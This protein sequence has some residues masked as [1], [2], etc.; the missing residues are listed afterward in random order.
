VFSQDSPISSPE[1]RRLFRRIQEALGGADKIAAVLDFERQV[2]AAS[3]N[4][5]TGQSI[6]EVVTRTRWVRP[7]DLRVDQVGPGSTYVLYFDGK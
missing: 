7:T 3:W 4:G 1:G 5:N 2:R 6:G